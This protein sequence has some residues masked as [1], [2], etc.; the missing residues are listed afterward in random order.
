V[1][2]VVEGFMMNEIVKRGEGRE[3]RLALYLPRR[4]RIVLDLVSPR[5]L[6][7]PQILV[8]TCPSH[9]QLSAA[10]ERTSVEV[11][12]WR[13]HV[14]VDSANDPDSLAAIVLRVP[15]N[16]A[17][18]IHTSMTHLLLQYLVVAD[19][20]HEVM[21]MSRDCPVDVMVVVLVVVVVEQ[22]KIF[23]VVLQQH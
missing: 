20:I 7:D 6:Q 13:I 4:G 22:M 11:A 2:G 5:L 8:E 15:R 14:L 17:W 10:V 16:L 1:R 18:L 19:R 23:V 3:S 9:H 21:L 12:H